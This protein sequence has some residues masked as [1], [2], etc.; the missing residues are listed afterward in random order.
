MGVRACVCVCV[1]LCVL[2]NIC[3]YVGRCLRCLRWMLDS[4]VQHTWSVLTLLDWDIAS[5]LHVWVWLCVGVVL[6]ESAALAHI[7]CGCVI[8]WLTMY[9]L[10][11]SVL[12]CMSVSGMYVCPLYMPVS[13]L[14]GWNIVSFSCV[15]VRCVCWGGPS[16]VCCFGT[17]Q[18]EGWPGWVTM[19]VLVCA[20]AGYAP[21]FPY[22]LFG[23]VCGRGLQK[24]QL[25]FS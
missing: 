19:W 18:I 17:R 11:M 6:I 7:D 12:Q 4:A 23:C 8:W 5:S 24:L 14:L 15:C 22:F 9:A 25:T 21:D 2:A 13:T 1:C 16:W 3:K 20:C 10:T